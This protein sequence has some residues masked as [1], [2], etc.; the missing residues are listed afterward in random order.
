ML[1][2]LVGSELYG[3]WLFFSEDDADEVIRAHVRRVFVTH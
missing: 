2:N 1:R 3:Y